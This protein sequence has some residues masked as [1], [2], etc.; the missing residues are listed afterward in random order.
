[1]GSLRAATVRER[2]LIQTRVR[3]PGAPPAGARSGNDVQFLADNLVT[4][5][6]PATLRQS[7]ANTRQNYSSP[8][9][10]CLLEMRR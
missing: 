2:H 6:P 10:D 3:L 1:L 5:Y 4:Q 9:I 7:G 8:L